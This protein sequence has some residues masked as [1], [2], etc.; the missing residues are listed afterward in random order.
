MTGS[1]KKR[2]LSANAIYALGLI[3]VVWAISL[4]ASV[5]PVSRDAL[6]HHLYVPK[7]YLQHGGIYELPHI[8]CSYYPMNLDLL[9]MIPLFFKNDIAPKY[10]HFAFSLATGFLIYRY[11]DRRINRTYA[12]LGSLFFLSIPV[13]VRLS[14]TVYV[15]LGLIFFLFAS[16]LCIFRWIETGFKTKYLIWGAVLCGLGLGTKYNGLIGL[17]LLGLFVPFVYSRYH[18]AHRYL[19]T[20]SLSCAAAFVLISLV[21]FSPWMIRNST[22]TGNPVYPL[23][24][25]V[26]NAIESKKAA[27]AENPEIEEHSQMSHIEIRRQIYG[28]SWLQIALIPVRIFFAGQDDN[29]ARFDGKTNPFLLL[30]PIFALMGIRKKNR[31]IRPEIL[32]MFSFS[33]LYFLF[34]SV[35]NHVRIRYISPILPTLVVLAMFGLKNLTKMI[36]GQAW[37]GS[38]ITGA[39]ICVAIIAV[40][41]GLNA[42]YLASRFKIDQPMEYLSGKITRDEYI[43][44]YRPEYEAFR[45]AN[46]HLTGDAKILG[47]FVGNRGYYS[48]VDIVFDLDILRRLAHES[49]SPADLSRKIKNRNFTHLLINYKPFNYWVGKYEAHEKTILN[50]FFQ[51]RVVTEFSKDGFGLLRL[52]ADNNPL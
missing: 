50:V 35:Q 51:T 3:G 19:W 20:K 12:L 26:F 13:I 41:L 4:L 18:T 14:S 1:W 46:E 25:G 38:K 40:M 10:I 52:A 24:Q 47:L 36:Q 5:P 45:Y 42:Q 15:D 28:E 8:I 2:L 16:Q 9:Y 29:P 37:R 11:I 22:W 32:L 7:L 48:D 34:A 39:G 31:Q 27:G 49:A 6:T 30:L 23:Y 21:F 17:F 33:I 43:Q 44:H